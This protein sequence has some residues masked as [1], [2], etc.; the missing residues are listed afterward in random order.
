MSGEIT[1]D[2][3]LVSL[4]LAEVSVVNCTVPEGALLPLKVTGSAAVRW[5]LNTISE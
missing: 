2:V 3:S 1:S 4:I 5:R